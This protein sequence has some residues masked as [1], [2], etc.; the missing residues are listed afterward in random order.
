[1]NVFPFQS[2][3]KEGATP[4]MAQL[5]GGCWRSGIRLR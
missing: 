2:H 5:G 3:A 1:L 4:K